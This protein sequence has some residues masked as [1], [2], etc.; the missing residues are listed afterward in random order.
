MPSVLNIRLQS[1]KNPVERAV[2]IEV[3]NRFYRP[4]MYADIRANHKEI[5]SYMEPLVV[6]IWSAILSDN[7]HIVAEGLIARAVGIMEPSAT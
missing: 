3:F 5:P 7:A 2:R 1:E 4:Q 6:I